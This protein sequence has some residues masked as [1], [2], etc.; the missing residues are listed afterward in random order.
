M[1]IKKYES[2]LKKGDVYKT[3]L[4]DSSIGQISLSI[5]VIDIKPEKMPLYIFH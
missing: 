1:I 2:Q 5:S 4:K 3:S